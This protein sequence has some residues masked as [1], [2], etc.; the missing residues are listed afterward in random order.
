ME[1]IARMEAEGGAEP[2]TEAAPAAA[3]PAASSAELAQARREAQEYLSALQYKT[4][5]F[6]NFRKR[7]RREMEERARRGLDVSELLPLMDDFDRATA[8]SAAGGDMAAF[9]DALSMLHSHL[10]G[11]LRARGVERRSS[12]GEPF[13]PRFH[14]AVMV[15]E[16][17]DYPDGTV[18]RE[19]EPLY[20]LDGETLRPARVVVCRRNDGAAPPEA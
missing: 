8:A 15:E 16:H 10:E 14:E 13:D 12:L 2:E 18:C 3:A 5:E 6:D 11:L 19:L 20:L 1:R 7:V 17:P 9:M 4:A